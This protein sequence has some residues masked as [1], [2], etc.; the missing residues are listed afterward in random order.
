MIEIILYTA[1]SC[2]HCPATKTL[3]DEFCAK[4]Q[5][6]SLRLVD[7]DSVSSTDLLMVGVSGTPSATL[8]G[9]ILFLSNN[10]PSCIEE[11]ERECR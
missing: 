11:V 4:H 1:K 2:P 10:V 3:L 8:D 9:R 7:V 5:D 6:F